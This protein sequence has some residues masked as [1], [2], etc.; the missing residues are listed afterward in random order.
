M[1]HAERAAVVVCGVSHENAIETCKIGRQAIKMHLCMVS[2][3]ESNGMEIAA[4]GATKSQFTRNQFAIYEFRICEAIS[5]YLFILCVFS[6]SHF[7]LVL[8]LNFGRFA[9]VCSEM[10]RTCTQHDRTWMVHA[11]SLIRAKTFVTICIDWDEPE[12]ELNGIAF[13]ESIKKWHLS[14]H[15]TRAIFFQ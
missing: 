15:R 3:M 2:W 12:I 11:M 10:Q 7:F 14:H 6:L 5:C 4:T 9:S 8:S 13:V 1:F